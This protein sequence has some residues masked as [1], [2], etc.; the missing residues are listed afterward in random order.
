MYV[1]SMKTFYFA[2][3][4]AAMKE[5]ASWASPALCNSGLSFTSEKP[6]REHRDTSV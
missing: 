2:E 6:R 3:A 1:T 4:T 5:Q